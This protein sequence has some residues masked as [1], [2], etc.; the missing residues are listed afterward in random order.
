MRFAV[1]VFYIGTEFDG[2][3]FQKDRRTVEKEIVDSLREAG[4]IKGKKEN[5][6]SYA[7]RTDKGVHAIGQVISFVSEKKVSLPEI[8][9]YLPFDIVVWGYVEVEESFNP[10]RD[11]KMRWYRY[12][13][14]Y[15]G[16]NIRLMRKASRILL[17]KKDFSFLS[18]RPGEN[19]F[20]VCEIHKVELGVL[21]NSLIFDMV[22]KSFRWE[23]VRRTWTALKM[24]GESLLTEEE[25]RMVLNKELRLPIRPSPPS[26][27]VLMD[28]YYALPFIVSYSSLK[29]ILHVIK[30][31]REEHPELTRVLD[32]IEQDINS[33]L[34]IT[35]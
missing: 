13:D 14:E 15:G 24:V 21:D 3:Q 4:Y 35:P 27:L 5:G 11:A 12:V 26:N 30:K 23:V 17:G 8:N 10:R 31:K 34:T 16:Q 9:D 19:E 33:R 1:K 32:V 28:V 22:G 20:N 6:F 7:G 29:E 25:L 18:K 2:F